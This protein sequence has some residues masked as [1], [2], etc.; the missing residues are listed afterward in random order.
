MRTT[1]TTEKLKVKYG[2]V[3]TH[4]GWYI[5]RDV[6]NGE[7]YVCRMDDSTYA[8]SSPK[9]NAER[10]VAC[11]N[12]CIGLSSEKLEA[13]LI[14]DMRIALGAA[15]SAIQELYH[16]LP[17]ERRERVLYYGDIIGQVVTKLKG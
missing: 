4:N 16:G 15:V 13:G 7:N 1:Y 12:A 2:Q 17:E 11:W 14:E 5:T 8:A 3:Y 9:D 10:L 6:A